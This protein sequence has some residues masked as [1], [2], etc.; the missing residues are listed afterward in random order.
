VSD[1]NGLSTPVNKESK[2]LLYVKPFGQGSASISQLE[3]DPASERYG[4]P[5]YYQ[6]S[7]TAP[8]QRATMDLRVHHSRVLH[9]S[10]DLLE[11]EYKGIPSL[12]AVFNRLMDLEKIVGGSGEMFWRGGRPGY[13][14]RIDPDAMMTDDQED[15]LS[16]QL[17]EYEHNLRRVLITEG[18]SLDSLSTQVADPSS[19]VDVQLQMISA[20]TGIP[21]RMLTGSERGELASTEDKTTWLDLIS[22]RRDNFAESQIIRPFVNMCIAAGVLPEA[23]ESYTIQWPDLYAPSSKEK[24]EVGKTRATALKEYSTNPVAETYV[25]PSAFYKLF[26]GLSDEEVEQLETAKEADIEEEQEAIRRAQQAG[27]EA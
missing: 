24:A 11:S 21:K 8:N 9:V 13:H 26:L 4:L 18:I 25:P 5:E 17:D 2:S 23:S 3:G 19:H 7:L 22:D 10:G 27:E 16:K 14:G 6:L 12:E 20:V 1:N 15:E